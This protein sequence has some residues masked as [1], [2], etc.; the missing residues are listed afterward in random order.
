MVMRELSALDTARQRLAHGDPAGTL[1]LLDQYARDNPH[2]LLQ[3]EAIVVRI[4]ALARQGKQGAARALAATFLQTHP[5]SPYA[6][7]V[8]MTVK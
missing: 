2:G 5:A 4:E 7:R 6:D 8:R 3:E 1:R